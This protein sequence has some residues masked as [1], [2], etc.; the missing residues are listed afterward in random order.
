M[1]L[2][3]RMFWSSLQCSIRTLPCKSPDV[4]LSVDTSSRILLVVGRY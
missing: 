3:A 1:H 2:Q 4:V